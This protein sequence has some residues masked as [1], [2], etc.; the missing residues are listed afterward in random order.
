[1][2]TAISSSDFKRN[3]QISFQRYINPNLYLKTATVTKEMSEKVY[4]VKSAMK[5]ILSRISKDSGLVEK[6]KSLSNKFKIFNNTLEISDIND[7][8]LEISMPEGFMRDVITMK[9]KKNDGKALNSI[10]LDGDKLVKNIENKRIEYINDKQ[11]N[12]K[13]IGNIIDFVSENAD[14]HLLS[15]RRFIK[16]NGVETAASKPVSKAGS[17]DDRAVSTVEDNN[18]MPDSIKNTLN[19]MK[20]GTYSFKELMNRGR[21]LGYKPKMVE[22]TGVVKNSVVNTGGI[23]R[24]H[25]PKILRKIGDRTLPSAVQN[26]QLPKTTINTPKVISKPELPQAARS[27]VTTQKSVE[28]SDNIVKKEN[29]FETAVKRTE[30]TVG[31]TQVFKLNPEIMEL[32]GKIKQ[33]YDKLSGD[34]V[35]RTRS[36]NYSRR[37]PKKS[38]FFSGTYFDFIQNN[39]MNISYTKHQGRY[40]EFYKI[41]EFDK[42]KLFDKNIFINTQGMVVKNTTKF[43][44]RDYINNNPLYYDKKEADR[45]GFNEYL[46]SKLEILDEF[47][48]EYLNFLV[49][50]EYTQKDCA[51]SYVMLNAGAIAKSLSDRLNSFV[52]DTFD[53]KSTQFSILKRKL[54][55]NCVSGYR[56]YISLFTDSNYTYGMSV[57]NSKAA[58]YKFWSDAPDINR[59]IFMTQD[60]KIYRN[61]ARGR[62]SFAGA[63]IMP[64]SS[65]FTQKEV[66]ENIEPKITKIIDV[67]ETGIKNI[68]DGNNKVTTK[69]LPEKFDDADIQYKLAQAKDIMDEAVVSLNNAI[70][71]IKD[72]F[73]TIKLFDKTV[74]DITEKFIKFWNSVEKKS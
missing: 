6:I 22:Y 17:F 36:T 29:V 1:M 38:N 65:F 28:N 21:D 71:T 49:N 4:S 39:G 46:R 3:N 35:L 58:K 59:T 23:K 24:I 11:V 5:E 51:G 74:N 14:M 30:T 44:G 45:L 66:L 61:V 67:I 10:T 63:Y 69:K 48:S 25:G 20:S 7:K 31:E 57:L 50:R 15:L 18:K 12:L 70:N 42:D 52:K 43:H 68:L 60:G 8:A 34:N 26:P 40:G 19:S 16:T 72:Q 64:R 37:F 56:K 54:G 13:D 27:T 73:G 41:R 9:I 33:K 55:A 32:L 53:N 47:S 2:I 62:G